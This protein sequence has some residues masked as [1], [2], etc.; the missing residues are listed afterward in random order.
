[1]LCIKKLTQQTFENNSDWLKRPIQT[2]LQ[3]F[4]GFPVETILKGDTKLTGVMCC[5]IFDQRYIAPSSSDF[6]RRPLPPLACELSL[7]RLEKQSPSQLSNL[8]LY[9]S[10]K[11][12]IYIHSLFHNHK[13][14]LLSSNSNS[15]FLSEKQ[16]QQVQA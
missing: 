13:F 7:R 8:F 11:K 4:L 9:F 15:C 6:R 5:H 10:I 1:M 2:H 3:T 14:Y 16:I 12:N